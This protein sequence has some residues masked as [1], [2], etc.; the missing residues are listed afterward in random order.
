MAEGL[1]FACVPAVS[2]P[3]GCEATFGSLV[4]SFSTLC[5]RFPVCVTGLDPGFRCGR[6]ILQPHRVGRGI[7]VADL[8][9]FEVIDFAMARRGSRLFCRAVHVDGV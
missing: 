2:G 3:G 9:C 6:E 1:A 5:S 8:T 4:I 7:Y